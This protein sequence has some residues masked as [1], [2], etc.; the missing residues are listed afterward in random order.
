MY[1]QV[2]NIDPGNLNAL[3]NRGICLQRLNKYELAVEDFTKIIETDKTNPSAFFNR[4]C[5]YDSLGL[6]DQAIEDYSFALGLEN[7]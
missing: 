6:I 1:S 5:C 4:G 2:V 3:H 7:K